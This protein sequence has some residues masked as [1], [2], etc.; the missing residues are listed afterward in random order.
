[1]SAS[2]DLTALLAELDGGDEEAV[3]RLLPHV[4]DELQVMAHRQLRGE[5]DGH[6]LNTTALVHE[7]YIK[8][9]DQK[10]ASWQ[11]RAHFFGIAA[12]AMRRILINYARQRQ[13][14]KRGGGVAVATFV[15]GEVAREARADE[16]APDA[17]LGRSIPRLWRQRRAYRPTEGRA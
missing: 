16:H 1:M 5:R 12:L 15:E 17:A 3:N 11:N 7:A 6:T 10:Q 14:E 8:L 9:A 4:Y 2:P 13:A